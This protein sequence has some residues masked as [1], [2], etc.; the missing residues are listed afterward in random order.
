MHDTTKGEVLSLTTPSNLQQCSG[1]DAKEEGKEV[2]HGPVIHLTNRQVGTAR[3]TE[4]QGRMN[5]TIS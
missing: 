4:R 3:R 5:E 2:E 1:K